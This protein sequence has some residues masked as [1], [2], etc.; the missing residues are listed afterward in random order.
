MVPELNT[1]SCI[2]VITGFRIRAS[3]GAT[4]VGMPMTATGRGARSCAAC[5]EGTD[6]SAK[7]RNE[8]SHELNELNELIR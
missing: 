3:M 6:S 8:I 1:T 2:R 4:S 5:A 7:I